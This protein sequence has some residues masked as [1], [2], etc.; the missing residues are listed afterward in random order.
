MICCH[1]IFRA[2]YCF[3]CDLVNGRSTPPGL[4]PPE[5]AQQEINQNI[6]LETLQPTHTFPGSILSVYL[7]VFIRRNFLQYL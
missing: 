3:V 2:I 4:P 1:V 6:T 5:P 7:K